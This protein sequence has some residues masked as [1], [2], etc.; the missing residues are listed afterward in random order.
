LI[1]C[2]SQILLSAPL[3]LALSPDLFALPLASALSY[4]IRS[5]RER[6]IATYRLSLLL[7]PSCFPF[8][9]AARESHQ[10]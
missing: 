9:V 5:L 10:F 8:V 4:Y 7:L 2:F 3:L 1:S 6:G